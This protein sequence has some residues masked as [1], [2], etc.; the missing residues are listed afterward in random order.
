MKEMG[1]YVEVTCKI[2]RRQFRKL[3]AIAGW[4]DKKIC[5]V[6]RKIISEYVNTKDVTEIV[7]LLEGR[8]KNE[9]GGER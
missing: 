7:A 6:I 1:R 3:A 5:T 8:K 2:P 4:E 9:G